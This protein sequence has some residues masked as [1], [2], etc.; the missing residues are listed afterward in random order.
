MHSIPVPWR[1]ASRFA[2][3][4]LVMLGVGS[5]NKEQE[6]GKYRRFACGDQPVDVDPNKG[7]QPQAVYVCAGDMVTWNSHG[8][9]FLVEFRK[10]SPFIDGR[11][12]FDNDH[13]K[14]DKAKPVGQLTVYEYRIT[15]DIG[16]AAPHVFEDPQVVDGGGTP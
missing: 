14:S 16:S 5:C 10:D 15:V 13:S 2:V 3:L 4:L 9:K 6:R 11:K 1:V 12:E 7:A 8:H